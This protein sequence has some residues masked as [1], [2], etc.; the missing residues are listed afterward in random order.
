MTHSTNHAVVA[1][2]LSQPTDVSA[3]LYRAALGPSGERYLAVFTKF[4]A[5]GRAG[6]HWHGL[7]CVSALNWMVARGL[8]VAAW[9][10]AG[11]AALGSVLVLGAARLLFDLVDRQL[12]VLLAALVLLASA[13]WGAFAHAF[14]YR[15]C[16]R[17]ILQAV[18]ASGNLGEACRRLEAQARRR[19][20]W[21]ALV[22]L[23][24]VGILVTMAALPWLRPPSAGPGPV[25]MSTPVSTVMPAP[26]P[27]SMP[28]PDATEAPPPVQ[29]Q[30]APSAADTAPAAPEAISATGLAPAPGPAPPDSDH[31]RAAARQGFAVQVGVFAR[32]ANVRKVLATLDKAAIAAYAE[33]AEPPADMPQRVRT[34]P[35][36]TREQ[37]MNAAERIR[38]LELPA[39]VVR[40]REDPPTP[41]AR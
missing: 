18:A 17:R 2:D 25:A 30:P 9:S 6:A 31:G 41:P 12:L 16:N 29:A 8:W 10:W 26:L 39:A 33:P 40:V 1:A 11:A 3:R 4:D 19:G 38:A 24:T 14:Y 20:R 35:Y 23:N 37:A 34:G 36:A 7:A 27:A 5:A 22:A 13:A 28:A 21:P 15:V 32:P